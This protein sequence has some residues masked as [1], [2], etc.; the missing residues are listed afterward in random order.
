M[1][2]Q[3]NSTKP[4]FKPGKMDIRILGDSSGKTYSTNFQIDGVETSADNGFALSVNK[5]HGIA[6][7][8]VV[9]NG[10]GFNQREYLLIY[11]G[12]KK[13]DAVYA[14]NIGSFSKVIAV[15]NV[16]PGKY[17]IKVGPPSGN[18][19]IITF[20]VDKNYENIFHWTKRHTD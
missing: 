18:G 4:E 10:S 9:I 20:E 14:D 5:Q 16:R 11:F 15:P 2:P 7:E 1:V 8:E 12:G 17:D 3:Y 19:Y 6:G 13:I